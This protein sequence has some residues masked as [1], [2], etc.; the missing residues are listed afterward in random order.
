MFN[1]IA[2]TSAISFI[3]Q[4]FLEVFGGKEASYITVVVGIIL[5]LL[6]TL[7]FGFTS[8]SCNNK[9][10]ASYSYCDITIT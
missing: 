1:T 5:Y 10:I 6:L 8:D 7:V 3:S 9:D 2:N 4:R